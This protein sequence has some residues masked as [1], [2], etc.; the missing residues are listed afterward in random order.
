MPEY[1]IQSC[2]KNT[3][4]LCQY[5]KLFTCA[6]QEFGKKIIVEDQLER[7][8]RSSTTNILSRMKYHIRA[9]R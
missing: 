3:V 1:I 9:E 8:Y 6:E 5:S 4:R 2:V 7:R